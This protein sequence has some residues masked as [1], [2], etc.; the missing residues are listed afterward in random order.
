VPGTTG[1]ENY[2]WS[3]DSGSVG[4]VAAGKIQRLDLAGGPPTVLGGVSDTLAGAWSPSGMILLGSY[5][6]LLQIPATGGKVT[7][8]IPLGENEAFFSAPQFLPDGRRFTFVAGVG[9]VVRGGGERRVMLGSLGSSEYT[10]LFDTNELR[11][12]LGLVR[13]HLLFVRGNAV[14]AQPFDE[15]R[16]APRGD[17][18]PIVA[19]VQLIPNRPYGAATVSPTGVVAYIAEND[20]AIHQ[21]RVVRSIRPPDRPPG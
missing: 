12:P 17:P 6:G 1:I 9:T 7:T 8:L 10:V 14:M 3:P 16:M 4:F 15:A 2:F 13:G 5:Q 20:R 21:A 19:P 18:V 11:F